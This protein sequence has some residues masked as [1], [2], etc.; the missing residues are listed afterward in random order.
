MDHKRMES[1]LYSLF[2]GEGAM[3]CCD[4][5]CFYEACPLQAES[6]CPLQEA[7]SLLEE[8]HFNDLEKNQ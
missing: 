7:L 1:I 3:F 5:C 4:K 2:G 6:Y 8:E